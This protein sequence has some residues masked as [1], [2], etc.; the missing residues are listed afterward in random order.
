MRQMMILG[1]AWSIN[2]YFKFL[3]MVIWTDILWLA[4]YHGIGNVIFHA[5]PRKIASHL[6]LTMQFGFEKCFKSH[7]GFMLL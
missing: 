4:S 1:I 3:G 5:F 7:R 2:S 6:S